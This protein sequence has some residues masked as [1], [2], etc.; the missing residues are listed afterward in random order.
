MT[1]LHDRIERRIKDLDLS[2]RAASIASG[3]SP[4]AINKLLSKREQSTTVSTIQKLARGLQTSAE[5]LAFG[6]ETSSPK[7]NAP[8]RYAPV[9]DQAYLVRGSVRA[10]RSDSILVTHEEVLEA[11]RGAWKMLQEKGQPDPVKLSEVA[12]DALIT[13][14]DDRIHNEKA[15][16]PRTEV[17]PKDPSSGAQSSRK[18]P[19]LNNP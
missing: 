18:K 6:V 1:E 5:W 4:D 9:R 11:I 3:L 19:R 15:V 13:N 10:L 16:S 14:S 8:E 17:V 2:D 12:L 7:T